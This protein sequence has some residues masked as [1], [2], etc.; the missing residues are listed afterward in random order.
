LGNSDVS[1]WRLQEGKT[2]ELHLC[3]TEKRRQG[4]ERKKKTKKI[5]NGRKNC[6]DKER[7]EPILDN[8]LRKN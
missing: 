1:Y 2:R 5:K 4:G 7:E 6:Q 3:E 8:E